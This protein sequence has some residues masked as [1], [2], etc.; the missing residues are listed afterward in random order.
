MAKEPK[1]SNVQMTYQVIQLKIKSVKSLMLIHEN[2]RYCQRQSLRLY[3]SCGQT[4]KSQKAFS[5]VKLR[6]LKVFLILI[7]SWEI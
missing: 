6:G 5:P 2:F 4:E 7:K 1:K 3:S